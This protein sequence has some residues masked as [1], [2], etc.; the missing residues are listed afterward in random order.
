MLW[1]SYDSL[2]MWENCLTAEVVG[3]AFP[4]AD[5]ANDVG[6][7]DLLTGARAPSWPIDL[8]SFADRRYSGNASHCFASESPS[9]PL[10]AITPRDGAIEWT[11][12]NE[13]VIYADDLR[14]VTHRG[15]NVL[16]GVEASTGAE[17]WSSVVVP[18]D[19]AEIYEPLWTT[20]ERGSSCPGLAITSWNIPGATPPARHAH[21][22][23]RAMAAAPRPPQ[24]RRPPASWPRP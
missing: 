22:R 12:P 16:T 8:P 1:T 11:R 24:T 21:T 17:L 3:G 9:G 18:A 19:G 7:L 14:L 4:H 20:V 2:E 13:S 6:A 15:V 5:E 10:Y 23:S